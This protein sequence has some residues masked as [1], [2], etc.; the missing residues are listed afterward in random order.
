M[1]VKVRPMRRFGRQFLSNEHNALPPHVG[2]LRVGEVRD[3]NLDRQVLRAQLVDLRSEADVI[4]VLND[5][6]LLWVGDSKMRLTGMESVG[7]VD[8]AQTWSVEFF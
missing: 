7:S 1:R 6:R 4:P 8:Y 3:L 5:A 2:T